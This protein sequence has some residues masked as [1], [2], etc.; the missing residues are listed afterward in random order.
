MP[1][2]SRK[3]T[4]KEATDG[5]KVDTVPQTAEPNAKDDIL[6]EV[7]EQ[8]A[9]PPPSTSGFDKKSLIEEATTNIMSQTAKVEASAKIR[10]TKKLSSCYKNMQ[11]I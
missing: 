7:T 5:R 10:S 3:A 1:L 6:P 11:K 2:F 8:T 9:Y 4:S